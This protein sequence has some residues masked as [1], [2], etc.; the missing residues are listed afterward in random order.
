MNTMQVEKLIFQLSRDGRS[1]NYVPEERD[2]SFIPE[3]MKR[4]R[5]L[6]LPSVPEN[7]VVRHFVR[8]SNLNYGVDTG[9]YPLGSCTM[10]YNPKI[11]EKIAR[12]PA[13]LNLHP[14]QDESTIQGALKIMYQLGEDLKLLSG[15]DGITL[16]PAAGAHGELTGILIS[17][18][19]HTAQGNPRKK[20]LVPDSSHGTN[21][22][23]AAMCG[24]RVVTLP[25]NERGTIDTKS[26]KENMDDE[27]AALMITNPN[28]LG[29]FENEIEE[30]ASIVHEKGGLLY[31]DGANMNAIMGYVRPGDM[32]FDMVHF[33]LHKTFSTPHGT[34]GPGAGPVAVKERLKPFLP[35]PTV[36]KNE[37][38]YFF[39]YSHR[40]TSIGK[41]RA[42]HGNFLILLRALL[43]IRSN[44]FSGLKRVSKHAVLNASYLKK[45]ISHLFE[46]PY[47]AATM[48]EFVLSASNLKKQY[49]IRTIDIAK[50]ILDFG[51]HAPTIY[52]PLIV[53]EALMIEPTES[54]TVENLDDFASVMEKIAEEAKK[55]P[56]ILHDAPHNTPVGR[57]DETTANRKPILKA[58]SLP[59]RRPDKQEG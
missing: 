36:G 44:G 25:S 33:N 56:S 45:K 18:A 16:Q 59:E 37:E 23:T 47:R 50:R 35:Y 1:G 55:N 48:H 12:D 49:G 39:D 15:M 46:D 22:A 5:P 26:L 21:P 28:T 19:Y 38:R 11:N 7:Q 54:E 53:K 6:N 20:I 32:G 57:P 14:Y 52:F 24:Y 8:L 27:V 43:Y 10:K 17:R 3:K 2:L 30:V 41:M 40:E 29:I 58:F 51:L 31:Y 34:G 42:F 13:F 4:E 9:M